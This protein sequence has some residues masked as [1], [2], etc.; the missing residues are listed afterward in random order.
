[1]PVYRTH[2]GPVWLA[3]LLLAGFAACAIARSAADEGAPDDRRGIR[4][5]PAVVVFE[6]WRDSVVFVTG[7][8]A[9]SGPLPLDEFFE[10]PTEKR[11]TSVGGGFVIHPSGYVLTNAHATARV[12]DH[13]VVLSNSK[14]YPAELAAL[15]PEED[16]ALLKIDAEGPLHAVRLAPA[17]DLMIGE[18]VV[19]I[20][21]PHGLRFTCTTGVLSAT[22][23]STNLLDMNGLRLEN[24]IQ[25]DAGIN[26]GSS[27]GPWLNI[28]GEVIGITASMKKNAENIAFA[29]PA[30]TIRREL[31]QMLDV[32]RRCGFRTGLAVSAGGP[33][34]VVTVDADSPAAKAGIQVGDVLTKLGNEPIPWGL[35][36]HLALVGRAPNEILPLELTRQGELIEASLELGKR[37]APDTAGLLLQKLGLTAGPLSEEKAREMLLKSARGVLI[38]E[39][40]AQRYENVEHKPAAGDVLAM[41]DKIRPRNLDQLGL[42][43][44]KLEPGR[45]VS[46][47]LLRRRGEDATRIDISVTLPP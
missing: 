8:L 2:G 42:L 3:V 39:V 41:I 43:L 7:P 15:V 17:D 16:L 10:L 5:T 36:Y 25:C 27:G 19:A 47:V 38:T 4:R 46:V 45:K 12:L 24:L 26:P 35:E 44:E 32:E 14:S 40:D 21:H 37:P 30:A 34:R 28:L 6:T 18:T 9:A 20:G 31:P 11:E 13:G 23:R 22:G 29:V 1:M 33:A